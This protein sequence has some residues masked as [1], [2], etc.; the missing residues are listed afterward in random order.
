MRILF[1]TVAKYISLGL[2]SFVDNFYSRSDTSGELGTSTSGS[3]WSPV[4]GIIEVVSGVAKASTTPTAY[5]A[6]SSYP[7]STVNMTDSNV[8]VKLSGINP[9]STAAIWVQS[10]EEWWGITARTELQEIPGNT[11]YG[12][13]YVITGNYPYTNY[14]ASNYYVYTKSN[15]NSYGFASYGTTN[16]G[17][18]GTSSST[19]GTTYSKVAYFVYGFSK[20]TTYSVA[21]YKYVATYGSKYN[22][23]YKI[24]YNKYTYTAANYKSASNYGYKTNG[25]YY[26]YNVSYN[27]NTVTN[28]KT[29]SNT[30]TNYGYNKYT[31]AN[32]GYDVYTLVN[33]YDGVGSNYGYGYSTTGTNATTYAVKQY[34]DII[35]STTSAVSTISSYLVSAVQTIGSFIVSLSGNEITV[36]PYSDTSFVSQIGSDLVYTATGAVISTQFGISISPSEYSQSDIIGSSVEIN[37]L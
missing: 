26:A 1:S 22:T 9:G 10:T 17:Y 33:S 7:M 30:V 6:G 37:T 29:V 21:S 12:Y 27:K 18:S 14:S 23:P 19:Y 31:T 13:Q 15:Y 36:K 4:N 2:S 20:S 34:I 3:K 25:T 16:Y 35:Q 5:S 8:E 24:A 28:Y 32:Y 11:N